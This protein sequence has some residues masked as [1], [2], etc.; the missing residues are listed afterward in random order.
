ML[1]DFHPISLLPICEKK[2]WQEYNIAQCAS[3]LVKQSG[4]ETDDSCF[5]QLLCTKHKIYTPLDD[6][7]VARVVF[8]DISKA[9]DKVWHLC[10]SL[11]IEAA[12]YSRY[13]LKNFD[14]FFKQQK[15]K[16]FRV[17]SS[18]VD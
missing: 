14:R 16:S 18:L 8:L 9:F 11:K 10:S 6:G 17:V 15:T 4:F 13:Y 1:R 3:F 2:Y 5:N 12:R 7:Y